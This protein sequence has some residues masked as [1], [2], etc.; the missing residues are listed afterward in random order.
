MSH[1]LLHLLVYSNSSWRPPAEPNAKINVDVS[2]N[3]SNATSC[4]GFIALDSAGL[5]LGSGFRHNENVHSSFA[6]EALAVIQ[7]LG[8]ALDLGLNKIELKGD[9]RAVIQ[10]IN[11]PST[12]F[13]VIRP[14]TSDAR[15]MASRFQFC[16]FNF[17]PRNCNLARMHYVEKA[18]G[19]RRTDTGSRMTQETFLLLLM[20]IAA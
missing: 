8:F 1:R 14:F 20:M 18:C 15:A 12:D 6:A 5:I 4:S 3:S 10:K 19:S 9:S 7:G 17:A 2:Y 16:T 13:S 11:S